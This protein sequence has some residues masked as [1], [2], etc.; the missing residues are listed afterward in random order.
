MK[1]WLVVNHF[2]HSGKFDLIYNWL[3]RAAENRGIE[4][5]RRTNAQLMS[6]IG[7]S[8]ASGRNTN[9]EHP[10]FVI[11][12][13][14]DVRL[15]KY[16]E[17]N[18]CRLFNSAR[19][20]EVCDDKALTHLSLAQSGIRMPKTII[21]PMT[22][23]TVGYGEYEFLELVAA[24]LGFPIV[25]KECFGS[26]GQQVYLAKDYAELIKVAGHIGTK[27][28]LFQEFIRTS[29]GRDIRINV[30]GSEP[31][32]AMMRYSDSDFRANITNGGRMKEYK[33]SAAQIEAAVKACKWLGLDFAGVDILFGEDDEPILC[34]VNSSAHFKSTYDCTGV[35]VADYII[36]H[37]IRELER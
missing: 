18:N 17:L 3:V 14:K 5:T 31:V 30:V 4:L 26:F 10:D 35:N 12:W 20:I 25:V 13:D 27:P 24:E 1:G 16:L 6:I 2:I 8:A 11:F 34:E 28:M 32:A 29:W 19:A 9:I 15:A 23:E 36:D 33:P 7:G 21:A 37:I 22:F